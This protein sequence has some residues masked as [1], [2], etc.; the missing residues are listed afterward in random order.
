MLQPL[1]K[2][3]PRLISTTSFLLLILF[4][5]CVESFTADYGRQILRV[6]RDLSG[7]FTRGLALSDYDWNQAAMYYGDSDP[8]DTL[9]RTIADNMGWFEFDYEYS[10]GGGYHWVDVTTEFSSPDELFILI[11]SVTSKQPGGS[12]GSGSESDLPYYSITMEDGFFRDTYYLQGTLLP[13]GNTGGAYEAT[14]YA[15]LPGKIVETNGRILDDNLVAW[16]WGYNDFVPYRLTTQVPNTGN[17]VLTVLVG[18]GILVGLGIFWV[19]KHQPLP[20]D[21]VEETMKGG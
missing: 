5:G 20:K 10:Q 1:H 3:S 11:E 17:I 9:A 2:R 6:N 4:T 19:Q 14:Y 7:T 21:P 18:I 16:D 15:E 8:A 13:L 12:G